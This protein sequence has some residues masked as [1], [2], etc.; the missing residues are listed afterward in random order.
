MQ[1][2]ANSA[3][4]LPLHLGPVSWQLWISS[5]RHSLNSVSK[6][7]SLR[8]NSTENGEFIHA[9]PWLWYWLFLYPQIGQDSSSSSRASTK[10][11][12]NRW[13][14]YEWWKAV[15]PNRRQELLPWRSWATLSQTTRQNLAGMQSHIADDSFN[16]FLVCSVLR[17]L[18]SVTM[19]SRQH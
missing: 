15:K 2:L 10:E 16:P 9:I 7:S 18:I 6:W 19:S 11:R 4:I 17:R 5:V 3:W 13:N 1:K 8:G 12:W 14:K